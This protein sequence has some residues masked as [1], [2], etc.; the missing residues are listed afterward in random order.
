MKSTSASTRLRNRSILA[1]DQLRGLLFGVLPRHKDMNENSNSISRFRPRASFARLA[2]NVAFLT[3]T[4]VGVAS[5]QTAALPAESAN[6]TIAQGQHEVGKTSY[7]T[8]PNG[9]RFT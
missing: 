3:F 4:G 9:T 5:A 8:R 6:F 1:P 7:T 2:W